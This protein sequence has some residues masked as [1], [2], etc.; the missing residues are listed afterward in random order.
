MIIIVLNS[1]QPP[2]PAIICYNS[3]KKKGKKK[4]K[5]VEVNDL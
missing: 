5:K 3:C 1:D 4:K 2:I